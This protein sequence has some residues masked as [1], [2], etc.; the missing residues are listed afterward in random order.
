MRTRLSL[1][2]PK[3]FTNSFLFQLKKIEAHL[4]TTKKSIAAVKMTLDLINTVQDLEYRKPLPPS[5]SMAHKEIRNINDLF[6]ANRVLSTEHQK[7]I[8]KNRE[9]YQKRANLFTK[10][11]APNQNIT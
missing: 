6:C 5:L 9:L 2:Y 11:F 8:I 7:L 10:Y 4:V 3:L 1:Q